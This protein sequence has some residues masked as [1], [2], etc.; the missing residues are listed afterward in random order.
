MKWELFDKKIL[1]FLVFSFYSQCPFNVL[2]NKF[3]I[4]YYE[5]CYPSYFLKFIE[6][7]NNL[8]FLAIVCASYNKTG[9]ARR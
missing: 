7:G 9:R 2:L 4:L 6:S 1:Q 3:A 8:D 5:L